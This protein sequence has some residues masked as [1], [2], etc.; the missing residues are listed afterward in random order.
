MRTNGGQFISHRQGQDVF[1]EQVLCIGGCRVMETT[2]SI[3]LLTRRLMQ[4]FTLYHEELLE[5]NFDIY[6]LFT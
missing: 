4:L 1:S 5:T 6:C 2:V 3:I